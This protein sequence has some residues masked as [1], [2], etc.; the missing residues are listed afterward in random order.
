M[1]DDDGGEQKVFGKHIIYRNVF[2]KKKKADNAGNVLY[3][4]SHNEI[5]ERIFMNAFLLYPS[6]QLT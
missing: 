6:K 4:S 3:R 1:S 5:C 2:V